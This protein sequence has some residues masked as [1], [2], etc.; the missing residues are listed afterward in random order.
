MTTDEELRY[1]SLFSDVGCL[2][3]GNH[4]SL[5]KIQIKFNSENSIYKCPEC[6]YENN[7]E[8]CMNRANILRD[9]SKIKIKKENARR[10]TLKYNRICDGR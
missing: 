2:N 6:G 10:N 3:C 7:V 1:K 8:D 9:E 4:E 5:T